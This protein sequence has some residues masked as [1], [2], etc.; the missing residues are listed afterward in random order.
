MVMQRPN[1]KTNSSA[2]YSQNSRTDRHRCFPIKTDKVTLTA[3]SSGYTKKCAGT[4]SDR[5]SSNDRLLE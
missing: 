4:C 1:Q 5:G 3:C 2:D